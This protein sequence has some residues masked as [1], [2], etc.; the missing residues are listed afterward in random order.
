MPVGALHDAALEAL[1]EGGRTLSGAKS[2]PAK[3]S[4]PDARRSGT[5]ANARCMARAS[6]KRSSRDLASARSTN[7]ASSG[8]T[9]ATCESG[10]GGSVAIFTTSPS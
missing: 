1:P 2:V 10:G 9:V 3:A 6:G 5:S 4:G 7:A 8:D